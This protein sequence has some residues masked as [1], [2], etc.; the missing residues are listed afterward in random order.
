VAVVGPDL[1]ASLFNEGEA[2]GEDIKIQGITFTVL[3]VLTEKGDGDR[4]NPDEAV[5]VP[6]TVAMKRMF[7]E[8]RINDIE[9]CAQDD[10]DMNAVEAGL[11]VLFRK[12]HGIVD[13]ED[14]DIRIFNQ[15]ELIEAT[16]KVGSTFTMLLGGIAGI[17]LLVGGIGI[18]NIMLVTVSERTREIGIR[19]AVGAQQWHILLQ[20]LLESMLISGLGGICGVALGYGIAYGIGSV[21]E[22]TPLVRIG[23]VILSL[24]VS[25]SVGVFFGYSPARRAARLDPIIALR[26][27]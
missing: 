1:A 5:I 13:G 25:V 20:F 24:T 11:Y 22:F 27:E 17:S 10:A 26:S 18:M 14:D 4:D 3:G 23:S 15:A 2:V 16:S 8:T 12:R 9:V 6:Y 21:T 19:K 7:G